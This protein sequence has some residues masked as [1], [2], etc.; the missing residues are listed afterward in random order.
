[1]NPALINLG[2]TGIGGEG[3][4]RHAGKATNHRYD[5]NTGWVP[6]GGDFLSRRP[7]PGLLRE[8]TSTFVLQTGRPP[9]VFRFSLY[10]LGLLCVMPWTDR[11]SLISG[12]AK[13]TKGV[14]RSELVKGG[15]VL[16]VHHCLAFSGHGACRFLFHIFLRLSPCV[17]TFV[18]VV[19]DDAD[20]ASA[21]ISDFETFA[22][23]PSSP[24]SVILG[25]PV[26]QHAALRLPLFPEESPGQT[27]A[28]V[29]VSSQQQ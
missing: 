2:L 12:T 4:P 14:G 9:G 6:T 17:S 26:A 11:A 3:F 19:N 22:T 29:V 1:M 18:C 25:A 8:R 16:S 20:A 13:G 10:I 28:T 15:P 5:M 7:W 21:K 27:T 24:T 23:A